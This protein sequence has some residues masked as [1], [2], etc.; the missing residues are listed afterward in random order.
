MMCN[1]EEL[2]VDTDGSIYLVSAEQYK[3]LEDVYACIKQGRISGEVLKGP[4]RTEEEKG[5]R[6]F[7]VSEVQD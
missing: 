7:S 4:G 5:S 3:F 2:P 6:I 1:W